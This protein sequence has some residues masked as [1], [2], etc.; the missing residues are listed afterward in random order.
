MGSITE[1]IANERK[2]YILGRNIGF[3]FGICAGVVLGVIGQGIAEHNRLKDLQNRFT[4]AVQQSF[5]KSY[6]KF[7]PSVYDLNA[8]KDSVPGT[9]VKRY[10]E[11][12]KA[13]IEGEAPKD[14][15]YNSQERLDEIAKEGKLERARL[16]I[17]AGE[18]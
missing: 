10:S 14:A 15:Y 17:E 12:K 13:Y 5:E 6:S 9:V 7:Q 1:I 2:Q 4:P 11:M 16:E 8:P 3:S 18:R